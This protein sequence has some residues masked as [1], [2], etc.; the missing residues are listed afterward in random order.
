MTTAKDFARGVRQSASLRDRLLQVASGT[1]TGAIIASAYGVKT[2]PPCFPGKACVTSDGY[3]M[4]DFIDSGGCLH[5]GAF[6]GA[7]D[8]L[9]GNLKALADHCELTAAE[10]EE[11]DAAVQ[12]WIT[13]RYS[14]TRSLVA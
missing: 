4:A 5:T 13:T 2:P 6:A 11:L 10:R 9:R 3:L 14:D 12:G 1:R 8:D 7:I